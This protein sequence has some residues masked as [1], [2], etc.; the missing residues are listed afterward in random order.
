MLQRA[1]SS[2]IRAGSAPWQ[3]LRVGV[4]IPVLDPDLARM[5]KHRELLSQVH[6]RGDA[7]WV[8]GLAVWDLYS[9]FSMGLMQ[10]SLSR[11]LGWYLYLAALSP[12]LLWRH[13]QWA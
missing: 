10:T 4:Q 7:T 3:G 9:L 8:C 13:V 11:A 5:P 6:A 1:C 2:N 12:I